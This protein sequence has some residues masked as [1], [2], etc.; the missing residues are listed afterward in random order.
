LN[1]FDDIIVNVHELTAIQ[2]KNIS[3]TDV[4]AAALG[5]VLALF[6]ISQKFI[7]LCIGIWILAVI[8]DGIKKKNKFVFSWQKAIL[9]LLFLLL[10][11][12]VFWSDN[13]DVAWFDL[14]VKMSLAIVP[15]LFMWL[16]Y[17]GRHLIL[18]LKCFIFGVAVGAILL[19]IAAGIQFEISQ[20]FL[21]LAQSETDREITNT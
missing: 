3:S 9:P 10:F 18:I 21:I 12:G 11:F 8:L 5:L 13:R 14:E 7:P 4:S 2:L 15:I 1:Y 6:S 19:F 16:D 17:Q 20:D